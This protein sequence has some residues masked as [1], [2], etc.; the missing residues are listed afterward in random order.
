MLQPRN[1]FDQADR[2]I[3]INYLE[4]SGS[5]DQLSDCDINSE[6]VD[7]CGRFEV[8][9]IV[10]QGTYMYMYMSGLYTVMRL[11]VS[12]KYMS[13]TGRNELQERWIINILHNII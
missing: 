6:V 1:R 8:A 10:C 9:G 4:C 2:P 12:M 5:E 13:S 3:V 11:E 7:T